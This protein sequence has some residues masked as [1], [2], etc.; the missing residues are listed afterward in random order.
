VSILDAPSITV[1]PAFAGQQASGRGLSVL[2]RSFPWLVRSR[3]ILLVL[4]A[5]WIINVFDLGYTLLEALYSDFIEMNP[6]AAKLIG[7]SPH[8]LVGYKTVL[9]AIGSAILLVCRRH[10]AAELGCW[11]L[12]GAYVCVAVRWWSYYE[13]RLTVFDD[14]A[15]NVDPLIGCCPF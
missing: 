6:L 15:V 8:V 1:S 3:R 10:R 13:Q 9:S 14:P 5:V 4:A 7:A 11:L 12:L 2:D